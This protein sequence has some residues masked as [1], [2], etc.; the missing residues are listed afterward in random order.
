MLVSSL[1][2]SLIERTDET[3]R[4]RF[5]VGFDSFLPLLRFLPQ[6]PSFVLFY[7][8]FILDFLLTTTDR[9]SG[10]GIER[11]SWVEYSTCRGDLMVRAERWSGVRVCLRPSCDP[12][13]Q[14]TNEVGW[15]CLPIVMA[16]RILTTGKYNLLGNVLVTRS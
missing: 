1:E 7:E 16:D 9:G 10:N 5:V 4:A 13:Y 6:V 2:G 14:I 11:F 8:N 12:N 15:A 3:A